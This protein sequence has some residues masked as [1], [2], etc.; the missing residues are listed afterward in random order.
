MKIVLKNIFIY[1]FG[2]FVLIQLIQ[3]D[4]K[5]TPTNPKE[6]IKAPKEV[7]SILKRACYDCHSNSVKL[8]WY[9]KIAPVSWTISRH[10]DIG[11]AWVNF[12]IWET[13][14]KEQKDKKLEEIYKAI[15]KAMPVPSY[16]SQHPEAKL[17]K[18]D[19]ELIR[20]WTGK[21]PF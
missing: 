15:Y 16:V 11:R 3:V 14:T 5:N 21:A 12:S 13:Y 10:V 2:A 8:P 1:L 7:M 9:S 18:E 19:R 20:N 6:E 17:S 4:I